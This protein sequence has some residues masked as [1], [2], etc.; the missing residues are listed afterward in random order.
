M[1]LII[2]IKTHQ[3][4]LALAVHTLLE[5]QY[6]YHPSRTFQP[7][8]ADS[9]RPV[10]PTSDTESPHRLPSSSNNPQH[11]LHNGPL[12]RRQLPPPQPRRPHRC[13][14]CHHDK[15]VLQPHYLDI[16]PTHNPN[17]DDPTRAT[18][19]HHPRALARPSQSPAIALTDGH[20]RYDPHGV[21][22]RTEL[23]DGVVLE[24]D[25]EWVS[26]S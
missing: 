17:P 11:A 18:D 1:K 14:R 13:L 10:K 9:H 4:R 16:P 12:H 3:R 20:G 23:H 19:R 6:L 24:V 26:E 5:S 8:A 25:A 21:Q 2:P 7:R 22:V 15:Q